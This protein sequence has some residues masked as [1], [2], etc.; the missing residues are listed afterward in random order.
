MPYDV[1]QA[2]VGGAIVVGGF[3]RG[4]EP[5]FVDTATAQTEGVEV[6]RVKFEARAGLEEGAGDPARSQAEQAAGLGEFLFHERGDAAL[7]SGEILDNLRGGH[8]RRKGES[9][10]SDLGDSVG[11]DKN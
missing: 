11:R 2:F 6:I 4:S 9:G 8:G 1:G 10:R 3:G 5:A 7:L